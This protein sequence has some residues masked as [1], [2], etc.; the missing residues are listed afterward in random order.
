MKRRG[1]TPDAVSR[2]KHAFH[3]LLHSK[4]RLDPALTRIRAE[5]GDSPEVGRL[6]AFLETSERGFLR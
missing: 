1:I 4:L 2:L 6:L 5:L 3:L